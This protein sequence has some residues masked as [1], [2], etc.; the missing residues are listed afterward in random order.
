MTKDKAMTKTVSRRG[1]LTLA[2]LA[3]SYLVAPAHAFAQVKAADS[4]TSVYTAPN[5]V[6]VVDIANP[7]GAGLSHNKYTDYNVDTKGLVLNNGDTSEMERQSQ[8][9]GAVPSN[10]HLTKSA[11]VILNMDET[12]TLE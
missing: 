3:A 9:A 6:P 12:I 10:L 4:A 1:R 7:N 5:G 2:L 11:S 8:L